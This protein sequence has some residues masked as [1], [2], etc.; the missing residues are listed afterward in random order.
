MERF[1]KNCKT[2]GKNSY[3][4]F[5]FSHFPLKSLFFHL[6]PRFLKTHRKLFFQKINIALRK[7]IYKKF[8]SFQ[9]LFQNFTNLI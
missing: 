8:Q 7:T 4:L 1:L 5:F 6:K 9:N 3:K 2:S